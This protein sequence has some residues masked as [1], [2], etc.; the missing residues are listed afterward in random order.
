MSDRTKKILHFIHEHRT[1][2]VLGFLVLIAIGIVQFP[3]AE[4]SILRLIDLT[5]AGLLAT[6]TWEIPMHRG[7]TELVDTA[8]GVRELARWIAIDGGIAIIAG[9]VNKSI[10]RVLSDAKR[11]RKRLGIEPIAAEEKISH[12]II[13]ASEI[14]SDFAQVISRSPEEKVVGIHV[15]DAVPYAYGQEIDHHINVSGLSEIV[16]RFTPAEKEIS[17]IEAS[18]LNR[19]KSITI[20]CVN[21]SN[22]IFY[23]GLG[24]EVSPDF[25]SSLLKRLGPA[26]LKDKRIDIV[27]PEVRY[28]GQTTLIEKE[29]SDIVSPVTFA[30]RIIKPEKLVLNKIGSVLKDAQTEDGLRVVLIGEGRESQD[31]EMLNSFKEALDDLSYKGKKATTILVTQNQVSGA[32]QLST[33]TKSEEGLRALFASGDVFI[34]YGD[35]DFGT[36]TIVRLLLTHQVAPKKI[37]AIVERTDMEFDYVELGIP[38][39]N[40]IFIYRE[41]L[42]CLK[43]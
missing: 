9:T 35:T 7:L 2:F 26:K 23:K 15:G 27:L 11:E 20:V 36:S 1:L 3:Y 13:G 37:L 22:A 30:L 38:Q 43:S 33:S 21:P 5:L 8:E 12:V 25:P 4:G 39:E 40:V 29:L 32:D 6:P 16:G 18:G 17:T 41:I 42:N 10:S 14:I 24:S 28:L 31:Q 19:A 34:C